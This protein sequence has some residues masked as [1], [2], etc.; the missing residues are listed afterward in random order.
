MKL[1]GDLLAKRSSEIFG[2]KLEQPESDF[3]DVSPAG[4]TPLFIDP[5][6]IFLWKVLVQIRFRI[7]QLT[8]QTVAY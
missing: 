1:K 5:S 4:D 7:L 8:S 2:L 3:A 6:A